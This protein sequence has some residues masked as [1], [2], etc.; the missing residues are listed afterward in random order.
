MSTLRVNTLQNTA[1]TDG[2]ISIDSSGHVTV[3][4]VAMPSSGPLSNRNKIINGDMRIDQRNNGVSVTPTGDLTYTVDRW[5][6]RNYSGTGR[7]SV[8]QDSASPNGIDPSAKLTVTTTDTPGTYGYAF[9]QRVE[10]YSFSQFAYGTAAAKSATISFWVRSSVTGTY[11]FSI[12]NGDGTRSYVAE[13]S[14]S[15][16][17]TWEYKTITF[18]GDTSGTWLT[19]NGIG[20]LLEWSL[21][22]QTAKE[23]TAGSWQAGNY[24]GTSNQTDWIANAGATF[25]ITGVQLEAGTVATPFERRSYGQELALCLRYFERGNGD[26]VSYGNSGAAI[27]RFTQ[28]F[29]VLKRI[30]PTV[31]IS[32]IGGTATTVVVAIVFGNLNGFSYGIGSTG[33]SQTLQSYWTAEAEL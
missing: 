20:A 14:I 18:A 11:C 7:F 19:T 12:R 31:A 21:G 1:T 24:V 28:N 13:Y 27:Q 8:Q 16:A 6:I 32:K 22:S 29:V 25:Y 10:G 2:G 9:S 15:S 4:G 26:C 33:S 30:A 17:D 23:T 5:L 3:D